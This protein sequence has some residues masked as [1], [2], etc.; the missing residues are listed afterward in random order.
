MIDFQLENCHEKCSAMFL[1][2]G[3]SQSEY[4]QKRIRQKFKDYKVYV[5]T[6]PIAAVSR[7]AAIYGLS[8]KNAKDDMSDMI[9]SRV[10]K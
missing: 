1:V 7:G 8:F 4:L 6:N 9:E 5:P 2:G 3:F 10:L